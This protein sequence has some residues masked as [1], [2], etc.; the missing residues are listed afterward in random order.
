MASL[1]SNVTGQFYLISDFRLL[2][3]YL[4]L[5]RSL[6]CPPVVSGFTL[7]V[8]LIPG[9]ILTFIFLFLPLT[10]SSM[11]S[12]GSSSMASLYDLVQFLGTTMEY[13][14]VS[15][16]GP[17]HQPTYSYQVI[18]GH[19]ASGGMG[20]SKKTAMRLAAQRM[21]DM[22]SGLAPLTNGQIPLPPVDDEIYSL[23]GLAN[24]CGALNHLCAIKAIPK[25]E[26][27][28][29]SKDL[30]GWNSACICTVPGFYEKGF[31]RKKKDARQ[32]AAQAVLIQLRL[33]FQ[34]AG[35]PV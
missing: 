21:F 23:S 6:F 13:R 10:T 8:V 3:Q 28:F 33:E 7:Y 31:G 5:P 4:G 16:K 12:V 9:S 32:D 15:A 14:L 27:K 34:D 29:V 1:C 35:H 11:A 25:P 26:Y 20:R 22:L 2:V 18:C 24:P 30:K 17:P 19:L